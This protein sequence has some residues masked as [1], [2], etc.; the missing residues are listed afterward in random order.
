MT[1]RPTLHIIAG[2]NGAGKT[3]LYLNRIKA[4]TF[5]AEFIN[6]DL[7]AQSHFGHP[8]D[9]QHESEKGQALADERRRQLMASRKSFVT[10]STFSH[11]SKLELV[12][13]ARALGYRIVMYHVHVASVA[14]SVLRVQARVAEGG[15]TV[16]EDKIRQRFQRNQ[17]IIR[18]A[19][20]TA[21]HAYVFDNSRLDQ[22]HQLILTLKKGQVTEAAN[23]LPSWAN[24]LYAAVLAT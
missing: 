4:L 7:L 24:E 5:G 2:P 13:D 16:P 10:E 19:V 22:P 1:A 15:H 14:L 18:Q 23:S 9:T 11:S 3:T 6:A 20:L 8:A 17:T 12:D 21:D